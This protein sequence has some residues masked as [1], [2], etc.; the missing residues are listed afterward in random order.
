MNMIT[1]E[2]RL[3][4]EREV[5]PEFRIRWSMEP[6]AAT[7]SLDALVEI[8][9]EL[10]EFWTE[11]FRQDC[12]THHRLLHSRGPADLVGIQADFMRRAVTDYRLHAATM[13]RLVERLWFARPAA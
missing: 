10:Q 7:A 9:A 11:R 1:H 8:G 4:V 3:H 2:D 6:W 12:A 13:S 5:H